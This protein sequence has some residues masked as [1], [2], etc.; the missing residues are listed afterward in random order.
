MTFVAE[1]DGSNPRNR[2]VALAGGVGGAKLALGL[3]RY[4]GT[5]KR[6]ADLTIIGNTGDDMEYLGLNISPDLDTVLYTLA[7]LVNPGP[8]WGLANDT[9]HALE[10]LG[11]YAQ[12]TWF[13]LGDRDLATH[14]IRTHRLRQGERL[15]VITDDLRRQLGVGCQLL[16]MC[17]EPVRTLVQTAE[18]GQLAFQEY[19]VK[20]R[21]ADT[22]TDLTFEGASAATVTPEVTQAV[23]QASLIVVCPSNPYLSIRPILAVPGMLETL[24]RGAT[25]VVIVS[26]IVG[27]AALKGPAASLM[28]SLG[29]EETA[30]ATGVARIYAGFAQRFVLDT[31]DAD[32]QA[33]IE[34]LNY[35]V[36]VT[37][38]VMQTEE[39]KIR[40]AQE[41]LTQFG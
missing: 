8:G 13:W 20:R 34:A 41:I 29:G 35:K 14:I 26:P 11:Q 39:D 24:R 23:S 9:G 21:A 4:L 17:D 30:S 15:T 32:Q 18:A 38:T 27:G 33:A 6:A 16:P 22:V 5:Q 10:M 1:A 19:F 7:G 36:L 12:D 31:L 25:N 28:Q 37:N 3:Y 40:L 2:I